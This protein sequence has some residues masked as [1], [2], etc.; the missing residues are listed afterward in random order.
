M[1]EQTTKMGPGGRALAEASPA[2]FGSSGSVNA[3]EE[4][5]IGGMV[6]TS[7]PAAGAVD[8]REPVEGHERFATGELAMACSHYELGVIS[9]VR[10]FRRGSR[11]SPKVV[12]ETS[13]GRVLIKRR[14]A[15]RDTARHVAFSHAVQDRL[16]ERSFPLAKLVRSREGLGSVAVAGHVYETFEFVNGSRYDRSDGQ[17]ADAGRSLAY[18]HR[19]LAGYDPPGRCPD[20]SYHG[21]VMVPEVLRGLAS[22]LSR[23]GISA[24]SERLASVYERAS[25]RVRELGLASWP[26]QVIHCDYHPGN[27]IF[28]GGLVRA[29]VDFDA[30]R[31]GPRVLDVANG[32]L[33]FSVTRS[34][35]DPAAWP[36]E[37][38]SVRLHAFLRAYDAVEGCILSHAELR[39]LPWLMVEALIAEAAMPIAATGRFGSID[40]GAF[41]DMVDRK[42][43]WLVD[44]HESLVAL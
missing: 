6:F 10:E 41:L 27:M 12:L 34:G 24:A 25:S 37:L 31:V 23:P 40:G 33:Q 9:S 2:L 29:L 44:S 26:R 20:G 21:N 39:A 1:G 22:S 16:R 42:V 14:S 13:R 30:S 43:T 38:D 19:L 32:A 36:V 35:V 7:A 18:F 8:E 17:T 4:T 5:S 28:A 11:R 3:S 15:G